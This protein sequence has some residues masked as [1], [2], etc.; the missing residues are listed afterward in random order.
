[1]VKNLLH[2]EL[3]EAWITIDKAFKVQYPLHMLPV[4]ILISPDIKK[5][6]M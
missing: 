6:K 2:L 4:L 3:R 5:I 1:M